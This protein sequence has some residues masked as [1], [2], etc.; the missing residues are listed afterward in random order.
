M[1]ERYGRAVH[2]NRARWVKAEGDRWAILS[3]EPWFGGEPTGDFAS[4]EH[5]LAPVKPGKV[6]CVGRNYVAHAAEMG[7]DVP[8]EPLI[9]LKPST[10]VCGPGD[11]IERPAA[12]QQV[13]HEAELG[14][15]IGKWIRDDTVE[16]AR[17][18]VFGLTCV[19]DVTARDIQRKENRFT[20]AKGF[21]SFCPVGPHIVTGVDPLDLEVRCTVNGEE[22]QRARTSAMV[23]DPYALVLF[24]NSVMTLE[25]GD[26]IATGTPAG[27]GPLVDGDSVTVA[28]EKVGELTN[29]VIDRG[30]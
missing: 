28:V 13:D 7:G 1:S 24:I 27:V 14:L 19:N 9:F 2:D 6:V 26:L 15:V 4:G 21:D 5:F 3:K 8:E 18:A 30:Y 12:S 29:P 25:P 23:F 11:S 20:R 22:R 17:A 10:A 16:A